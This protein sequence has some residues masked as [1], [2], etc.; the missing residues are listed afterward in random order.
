MEVP[1]QYVIHN[2]QSPA[3][4]A[5]SSSTLRPRPSSSCQAAEN[6]YQDSSNT[7]T[8]AQVVQGLTAMTHT[9]TQ[10][11][12]ELLITNSCRDVQHGRNDQCS[13]FITT[14]K[15]IHCMCR[16]HPYPP[17]N[18]PRFRMMLNSFL[19]LAVYRYRYATIHRPIKYQ[20][21]CILYK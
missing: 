4:P 9:H 5:F 16:T 18:S 2:A 1:T 11:L 15:G 10:S 21:N 14:V 12:G 13:S 3:L 20:D 19:E 6:D 8:S 17:A 7:N